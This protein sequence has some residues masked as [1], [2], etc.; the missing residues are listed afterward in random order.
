MKKKPTYAEALAELEKLSEEIETGHADPDTL[1]QKIK[2]SLELVNYC[3]ERLR[4]TEDELG[5]LKSL[6]E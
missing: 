3:R 1:L 5:K 2:R 6:G 4:E